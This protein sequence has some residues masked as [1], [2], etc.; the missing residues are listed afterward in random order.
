MSRQKR[1][2]KK[3][4]NS[5]SGDAIVPESSLFGENNETV[6]P[7]RG[8]VQFGNLNIWVTKINNTNNDAPLVKK[9]PSEHN[10][11]EIVIPENILT[12]LSTP[13]VSDQTMS[14]E[15]R[16]EEDYL[17]NI[18][19][20][21]KKKKYEHYSTTPGEEVFPLFE[22]LCELLEFPLEKKTNI[23]CWWCCHRFDNTPCVFPTKYVKGV[24]QYTGNFCSWPC[25]RAYTSKDK[26]IC[27]RYKQNLLALFLLKLY[28]PLNDS[29]ERF[30]PDTGVA[31][32]RQ[33]LKM[34]GG[35][36]SITEFR[37]SSK[38]FKYTKISKISGILDR[39]I[40]LYRKVKD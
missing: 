33:S 20:Y 40:Y 37:E 26:S 9:I 25:V 29:G 16:V 21:A 35:M 3:V 4:C 36:L 2:R 10:L 28:R 8:T 31:P 38:K 27:N 5:Y 23:C 15:Y 12:T 18:P 39:N 1:G 7:D 24:F 32:P 6:S 17:L 30:S 14:G 19:K 22:N 11:C 34:F 13:I